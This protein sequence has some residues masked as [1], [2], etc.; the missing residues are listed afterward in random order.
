MYMRMI[1]IIVINNRSIV[2]VMNIYITK[3]NEEYLR[4]FNGKGESM[5][6]YIN[7]LLEN[8]RGMTKA[9]DAMN[10]APVPT[11]DRTWAEEDE[12]E[13]DPYEGYVLDV[14]GNTGVY[15][16]DGEPVE[17]DPAMVKELKKRG[18]VA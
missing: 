5:S 12:E 15:D 10:A 14:T 4:G 9:N 6:G 13:I 11:E 17:S 2:I 1:I 18:Q 8:A 7:R 3:E 16:A